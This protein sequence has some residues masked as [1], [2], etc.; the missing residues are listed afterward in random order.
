MTDRIESVLEGWRG[1]PY[2]RGQSCRGVGVDCVRLVAAALAELEGVPVPELPR[3]PQ[4]VGWHDQAIADK[5]ARALVRAFWPAEQIV[6]RHVEPG[7][8]V[9]VSPADGGGSHVFIV[10]G[11]VGLWHAHY[12]RVMRTGMSVGPGFKIHRV[13]RLRG[14]AE[15]WKARAS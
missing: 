5:G 10:G 7:D 9:E 6:S 11:K 12:P 2:M 14:R 3:L 15:R 4:D 8:I 1:T 13:W